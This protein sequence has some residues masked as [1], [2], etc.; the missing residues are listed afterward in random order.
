ME[1]MLEL[2]VILSITHSK[3]LVPKPHTTWDAPEEYVPSV[4][5]EVLPPSQFILS[6]EHSKVSSSS[7]AIALSQYGSLA[8]TLNVLVYVVFK[9]I[10]TESAI[11][12]F[13]VRVLSSLLKTV[14]RYPCFIPSP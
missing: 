9:E 14:K 5:V 1:T 11:Y 6:A 2:Y 7:N 3:L 12:C 10:P 4:N 8:F 13:K